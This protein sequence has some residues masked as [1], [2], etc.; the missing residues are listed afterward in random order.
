MIPIQVKLIILAG[1]IAVTGYLTYNYVTGQEAKKEVKVITDKVENH[2]EDVISLEEHTK[3]I[4]SLAR[5]Y[6]TQLDSIEPIR[7]PPITIYETAD[8]DSCLK[9]I[10]EHE[11]MYNEAIGIANTVSF[12]N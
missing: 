5:A 4:E 2:N 1:I 11:R 3:Q 12:E 10:D 9:L 6:E 7:L 8:L